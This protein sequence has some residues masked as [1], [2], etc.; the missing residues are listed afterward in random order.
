[1]GYKSYSK[2]SFGGNISGG[3]LKPPTFFRK[4][5]DQPPKKSYGSPF[6]KSYSRG[7]P[8]ESVVPTLYEI[9]KSAKK[10]S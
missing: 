3:S 1:P 10:W 4:K 6:S 5:Y 9:K 8:R 7:V 2:K